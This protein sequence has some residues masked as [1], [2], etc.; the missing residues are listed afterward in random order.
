MSIAI[1]NT[2]SVHFLF[3]LKKLFGFMPYLNALNVDSIIGS[4]KYLNYNRVMTGHLVLYNIWL[5]R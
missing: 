3:S 4:K 2:Y 5:V 1:L